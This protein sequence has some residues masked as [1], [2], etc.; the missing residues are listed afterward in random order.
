[1]TFRPFG[2]PE[3]RLEDTDFEHRN[4]LFLLKRRKN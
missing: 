1:M 2:L 4:F 3:L